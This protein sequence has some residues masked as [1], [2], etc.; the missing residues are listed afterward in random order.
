[1]KAMKTVLPTLALLFASLPAYA[2]ST[3][4]VSRIYPSGDTINFQLKDA[5][6]TGTVYWQFDIRTDIG[7]AWYA[8]LLS[9]ATTGRPVNIDYPGECNPSAHQ[10]I[11]YVY[12]DF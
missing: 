6:K 4:L 2:G 11:W 1:M 5:C 3:G 10:T 9:A 8:L 7:K 12:Q